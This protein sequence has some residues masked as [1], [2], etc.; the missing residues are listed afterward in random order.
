[1]KPSIIKA[2][3]FGKLF[4]QSR[5]VSGAQKNVS[6]SEGKIFPKQT[7]F[8]GKADAKHLQIFVGCVGNEL[9]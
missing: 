9:F 8:P 7:A 2:P 5:Q 6:F 1:M 4:L 3:E